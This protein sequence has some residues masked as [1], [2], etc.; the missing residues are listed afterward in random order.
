MCIQAL[1]QALYLSL[2]LSNAAYLPWKL[3]W[4]HPTWAGHL[5]HCS[6]ASSVF[7]I[8]LN[9]WPLPGLPAQLMGSRCFYLPCIP[10][11]LRTATWKFKSKAKQW[12]QKLFGIC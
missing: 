4:I 6:R 8:F 2:L 3:F 7:P 10:T 12:G 5:S 11:T 1:F 9:T